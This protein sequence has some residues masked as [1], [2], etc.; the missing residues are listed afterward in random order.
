MA[1]SAKALRVLV[2]DDNRDGAD[3]LG[4]RR[5]K[6]WFFLWVRDPS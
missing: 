3:A 6:V 2:V 5:A 1:T 4:V